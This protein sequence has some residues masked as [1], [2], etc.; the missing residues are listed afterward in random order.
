M[1]DTIRTQY[2]YAGFVPIDTAL[3]ERVQVLA[4]KSEGEIG[5]QIYGLRLLSP[6]PDALTDVKDLA[7]RFDHTIPLARLLLL[8]KMR[9]PF[10]F[11]A[12]RS[13]QFFAGKN[14]RMGDTD[15]S[16]KPISTLLEIVHWTCFTMQKWLQ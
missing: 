5:N 1:L 6:A 7:L 16:Y 14:Q 2:E 12:M 13:V 3:V 10:P 11:V 8:I 9:S 4:A 15:N